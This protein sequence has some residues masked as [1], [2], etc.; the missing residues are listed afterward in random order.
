MNLLGEPLRVGRL[1]HT[2][3]RRVAPETVRFYADTFADRHSAYAGPE[4]VAPPLL[5][6]SEVY[7]HPERWYLKRLVG[8]LHARQEWLLFAP[9]RPG[10]TVRT[11][12][13]V[14][15]RYRKR[16]RDYVLNEV[17]YCDDEGRLLVR[18]RTHQSFLAGE[19]EAQEG[20]V[21]DRSS[22]AKKERRPVGEGPGPELETVS[23]TVDLEMCTVADDSGWVESF[24]I[25]DFRRRCLLDGLDDI[26]L[27][28]QQADRIADYERRRFPE[29]RDRSVRRTDPNLR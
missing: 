29:A 6:H 9:L 15:E 26:G 14:V 12:S 21:V 16:N 4:P 17:D 1:V 24:A 10:T 20:F 8:N 3:E 19:P 27:T 2:A 18:G 13:M 23:L 11:R 25:D 7:Q 5:F 22:A 28:L